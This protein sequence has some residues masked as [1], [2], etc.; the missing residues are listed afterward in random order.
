MQHLR[1]E[2]AFRANLTIKYKFI[3]RF[4]LP[5]FA[6]RHVVTCLLDTNDH[7][8]AASATVAA[9]W[10]QGLDLHTRLPTG[11]IGITEAKLPKKFH[12]SN[13]VTFPKKT[14]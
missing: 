2:I 13:V 12:L 11:Y 3:Q 5:A 9:A 6:C 4:D 1:E 8:R 14:A 10:I 7:A